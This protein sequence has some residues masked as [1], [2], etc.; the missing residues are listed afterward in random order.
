M[1][2]ALVRSA[3]H[4]TG[5]ITC[6]VIAEIIDRG[7]HLCAYVGVGVLACQLTSAFTLTLYNKETSLSSSLLS[8]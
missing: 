2:N 3:L 7:M 8:N 6:E 5:L 4:G 1:L